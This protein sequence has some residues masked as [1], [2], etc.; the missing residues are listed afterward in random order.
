MKLAVI[1]LVR[2]EIDIIGVFLQHLDALFDHVLLMDHGSI[3]GTDLVME[4][5]CAGRPGWTMW[6][7]DPV[8]Y[9][10]AAFG[11]FALQHMMRHT[12]ADIALF[13]DADEFIDA[14][15][16]GT[17]ET[18]L[19]KLTDPDLVG[20][21]RWRNVVPARLDTRAIG[22]EE[23]IWRAPDRSPLGKVVLTRDFCTR[24]GHEV[25]LAVGNHG[26]FYLP[27][28]VVPGIQAGEI[29]HLPIRSHAQL[30]TKVLAGVFSIM[31]HANRAPTQGGHWYDILWRIADGTLRDED[32]I[33]I[34]ARYG[35]PDGQSASPMSW[36]TLQANGFTPTSLRVALGRPSA[37]INAPLSVDVA[38]LVATILRRFT[39]ED[40]ANCALKLD[41]TRLRFVPSAI[42]APSTP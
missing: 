17:L 38:R 1:A 24:H 9:H 25:H 26:V 36:A 40:D 4:Q 3:D 5:T 29:L 14:P 33:G 41:G 6:R 7:L 2:N 30:K 15:D 42:P 22:P 18:A 37:T 34:A 10:Q 13:L 20:T 35:A 32:I 39:I 27:D 21:L 16:R 31:S 11:A 23:A 8:G 12:D 19:A 28:R